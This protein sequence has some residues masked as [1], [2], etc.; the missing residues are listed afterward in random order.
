M[1]RGGGEEEEK[2]YVEFEA[3]MRVLLRVL[4]GLV[5]SHTAPWVE[6][7]LVRLDFNG[8]FSKGTG[9]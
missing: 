6:G 2:A 5:E 3:Q 8:H 7:L 4:G 9:R 1:G